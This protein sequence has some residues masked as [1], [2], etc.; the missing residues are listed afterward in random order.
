MRESF[1]AVNGFSAESS[2]LARCFDAFSSRE[3]VSTARKRS[4]EVET[5]AWLTQ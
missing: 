5:A 4:N 3:P 2:P 1:I